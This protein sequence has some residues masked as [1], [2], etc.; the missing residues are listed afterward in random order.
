MWRSDGRCGL[1]NTLPDGQPGQCDPDGGS[2]CCNGLDYGKCG[3]STEDCTCEYCTDYRIIYKGWR[4]SGGEQRWRYDGKCGSYYPLPDGSVTG[5]DPDGE[6]PCCSNK[7]NGEC[8]NTTKHCSC[9]SCKDYKFE[10]WWIESGGKQKWRDDGKCGIYY[11]LPDGTTSQCNPDGESPCCTDIW[12]GECGNTT[13]NCTCYDCSDYR[14]I[15]K[16]WR[17]SVGEQKWRYDGECGAG[18]PLPDGTA[19]QCNPVGARP[20]CN[21]ALYGKC[22]NTTEHCSCTYCTDYEIM[23]K[24]R[25]ES[26]REQMWRYD[27]KCGSRYPLID[28][29]A[30][31]CNPD[32]KNPCCSNIR[33]GKCGN[34][35]EHCSCQDC[36]DYRVIYSQWK[37]SRGK[38]K[39]RY[40]GLCGYRQSLPDGT[41]AECDPNGEKPFCDNLWSGKCREHCS[42]DL[43]INYRVINNKVENSGDKKRWRDDGQCGY[44]Y[45]LSGDTGVECD[46]EGEHPC[47]SD[48][49]N[50]ECGNTTEHCSCKNC[51]DFKFG[52]WWRE[53]EIK[54]KWREDGRCGYYYSLPDGT[55]AQC[56]PDGDNP[57]CSDTWNGVCV[58]T[59]EDCSCEDCTNYGVLYKEWRESGGK[60]RWRTDGKCGGMYPLP[61]GTAAQCDPDGENPCCSKVWYG[62]CGNTTEHCSSDHCTDY[63]ILYKDWRESGGKQKWRYDGRC[64]SSYQ[65]P[66][67]RPSE[68]NPDGENPCCNGFWCSNDKNND[69]ICYNC[70]DFRMVKKIRES[71]NNCTTI[72]LP[73]GYFKNVC[74]DESTSYLYFKCAYSQTYYKPIFKDNRDLG[75]VTEVCENDPHAYQACWFR[76]HITN[77]DVLC[78]GYYCE[79]KEY[80]AY[81]GYIECKGD[82]CKAENRDCVYK[83]DGTTLCDD[84][85]DLNYCE[86]ESYCNE[87]IYGVICS[88]SYGDKIHVPA[89]WICDG[90]KDCDDLS[91][92]QNCNVT[93]SI[94]QSCTNYYSQVEKNITLTVPINN[95]TRCSAFDVR[96]HY[97]EYPYAYCLN[98]LDQTNCSDIGR[99]GGYCRVNGFMSS[100]SKYM[101]CNEYDPTAELPIKICD[102]NIQ[103]SCLSEDELV[104][105][106]IHKHRMCDGLEDCSLGIEE[107]HSIC[108]IMTDAFNFTCIRTFHPKLKD[109]EIPVSWI[110][111]NE[112]DCMNGEDENVNLW[113]FCKSGQIL[114]PGR[115]CQ[116][117]YLC[118]TGSRKSYVQFDFLCDGIESCVDGGESKVCKISRDM[119]AI[120]K[121]AFYNS[122]IQTVCNSTLSTCELM[123][124]R[125][126]WGDIFGERKIEIY[127]PT[128]KVSCRG[129]FGEYYLYLSCMDLCE[130]S[131]VKC[132]LGV[133]ERKLM[134]NSCPSQYPNRTY[135]LA[136]NSFLTFLN[137]SVN[138]GYHQNFYQCDNSRCIEYKLVCDLNDDCGDMSDEINCINHMVCKNTFNTSKQQFIALSQ[139][140]DGL[141]DCFDLSDECNEDCG[142]EILENWVLKI[143][144]WFMGI[145]ALLFNIFTVLNGSSSLKD[146]KSKQMITSKLLMTLIGLGDLFIGLYLVILSTYDTIIFGREFCKNQAEWLTGTPCLVLGV[147][148]TVGSQVSLF[149]MTV[150]SV[151]RVYG[152]TCKPMRVPGPV[153]KTSILRITSL[154]IFTVGAAVAIAV[155]PLASSLEDYFVQGMH[156]NSSYKVFIGFPNKD[157][158]QKILK[159]YFEQNTSTN[160]STISRSMSWKDIGDKVDSM[161]SQDYG[162]LTRSPV[163]FYG[164][165]GVCLFKYFVRTDDARRSRQSTNEVEFQGDPVVWIVLAVNL[166]CFM[167]I[168][169]SYILIACKT[170]LSSKRSGQHDNQERQR[171]ERAINNKIMIIIMTDFLCWVPFII[172]SALHNLKY[173]DASH[174]YTSFAMTVLPLNSVIN[175]LV[176]DKAL[177]ELITRSIQRLTAVIGLRTMPILEQPPEVTAIE[178]VACGDSDN[179]CKRSRNTDKKHGP[180]NESDDNEDK[181]KIHDKEIDTGCHDNQHCSDGHNKFGTARKEN[182]HSDCN[183][184]TDDDNINEIDI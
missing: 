79:N 98:Y 105:C 81:Q 9:R 73:N 31:Q 151:I 145:L 82:N 55:A 48:T 10:K 63:R 71:G 113:R 90:V 91:D 173:I 139:K 75:S 154:V 96:K 110:M 123:E 142:R 130:E 115:M 148:S 25:E 122:T 12:Y 109:H 22:G 41:P 174:W 99:V 21:S 172:I 87:Y 3:N 62:R 74:F 112:T 72:N 118:P 27:G 49:W 137:D 39:W 56:D 85:C 116:D 164:N 67:G 179:G 106:K 11:A 84:K 15:Y 6:N 57:C 8:G 78:G 14:I 5:C 66:D 93:D 77:A 180:D 160:T 131:D 136:N 17:E 175:P 163:H 152:L 54:Q 33:Y 101:I 153:K 124:F 146:C 37:D 59:T 104:D 158:H 165:D 138:A 157:R 161:F 94:S 53:S 182:D 169:C 178:C 36:T 65:L 50:G 143:I 60:Q 126:P 45:N 69:C 19:A 38:Q 162:N 120:N 107:S 125:R 97:N 70:L 177:G 144:C 108:Q 127:V 47:C 183:G 184:F 129:Q 100:V 89:G 7:W 46:P 95:Y 141:Y 26:G 147:I 76:E 2:P 24:E 30:A 51:K 167:V 134:H 159:T 68:C 166:F 34:S 149:A 88:T 117:V 181:Q 132:P 92:E 58:N 171:N 156:Y 176:Y 61:D 168:T 13:E 35:T 23:Y 133:G 40:D 150:F 43:C 155:I 20:C 4:E 28:G 119:P 103:N 64:G 18:F 111:D 135:T 128:S 121:A 44:V 140:C 52:K 83:I 29:T 114:Y 80:W 16:D 102:D 42:S 1:Q 86:D 170:R 32:G